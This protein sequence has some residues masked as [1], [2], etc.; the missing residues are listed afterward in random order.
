MLDMCSSKLRECLAMK[1]P[2]SA[3]LEV[4]DFRLHRDNNA[5]ASATITAMF[6]SLSVVDLRHL[7]R[8]SARSKW[9]KNFQQPQQRR[10]L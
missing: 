4:V 1:L 8:S 3:S 10:S 9:G 7:A 2:H 6:V 5:I